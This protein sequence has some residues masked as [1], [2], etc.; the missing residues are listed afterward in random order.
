MQKLLIVEDN[1]NLGR[2]TAR[3][4][5][6]VLENVE[7]VTVLSCAGARVAATDHRPSVVVI[8]VNLPDGNGIDLAG[9]LAKLVPECKAILISADRPQEVPLTVFGFLLKPYK[10]DSLAEL[11]R[12]ALAT[13]SPPAASGGGALTA[14]P[15]NAD[16]PLCPDRHWVRNRLAGLLV[17]LRAFGADLKADCGDPEAVRGD[18]DRYLEHLCETVI[19]ISR[20]CRE[21]CGR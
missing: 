15:G 6:H 16:G 2:F 1:L 3:H 18:V 9:E 19:E 20:M 4:L 8:D 14:Q 7:V 17:G 11:I 5:Q 10:I 21:G 13:S 12:A